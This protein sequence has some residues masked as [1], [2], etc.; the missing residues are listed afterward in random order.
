M[1]ATLPSFGMQVGGAAVPHQG[2][3]LASTKQPYTGGGVVGFDSSF[4]LTAIDTVR[5]HLVRRQVAKAFC[6][7]R[8]RWLD[9]P[10]KQIF[11]M[12]PG[13][14]KHFVCLV[15]RKRAAGFC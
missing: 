5:R 4:P 12:P 2:W 7:G 9:V 6:S 3:A 1:L 14:L 15:L 8:V 10:G 11:A 13:I